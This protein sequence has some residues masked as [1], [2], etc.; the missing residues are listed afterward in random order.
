MTGTTLRRSSY[1]LP[2]D[3]VGVSPPSTGSAAWARGRNRHRD[4]LRG[5][6]GVS[7][8]AVDRALRSQLLRAIGRP[9]RRGRL[10]GQLWARSRRRRPGRPVEPS[11]A[12]PGPP[13]PSGGDAAGSSRARAGARNGAGSRFDN[14]GRR[15][16]GAAASAPGGRRQFLGWCCRWLPRCSGLRRWPSWCFP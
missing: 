13:A 1:V 8:R 3:G 10:I 6:D 14:R 7:Q 5:G 12:G 9:P 16:S 2:S 4:G 11:P 15:D